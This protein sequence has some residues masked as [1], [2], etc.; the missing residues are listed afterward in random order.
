METKNKS[1]TQIFGCKNE[2]FLKTL[3]A[4]SYE[5]ERRVNEVLMWFTKYY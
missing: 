3:A 1:R 5:V 4:I 2:I